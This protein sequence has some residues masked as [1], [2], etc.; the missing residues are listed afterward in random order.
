MWPIRLGGRDAGNSLSRI[1]AWIMDHAWGASLSLNH[2]RFAEFLD[3]LAGGDGNPSVRIVLGDLFQQLYIVFSFNGRSSKQAANKKAPVAAIATDNSWG[4]KS[5]R[6]IGSALNLKN[7]LG[8][9]DDDHHDHA[10]KDGDGHV[11][12]E[13]LRTRLSINICSALRAAAGG[14]DK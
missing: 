2:F 8:H 5:S 12:M 6:F 9:Y 3:P 10:D 1:G 11:E 14:P 13:P 4:R 7:G